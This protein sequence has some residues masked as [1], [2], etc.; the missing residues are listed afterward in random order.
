MTKGSRDIY[1]NQA[2]SWLETPGIK[3]LVCLGDMKGRGH[4]EYFGILSELVR[5][6]MEWMY[7]VQYMAH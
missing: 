4:A 7:F 3:A 5:K 1:R 2:G 6:D